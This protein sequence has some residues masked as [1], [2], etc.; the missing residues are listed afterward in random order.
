M[1]CIQW[2]SLVTQRKAPISILKWTK[3]VFNNSLESAWKFSP[4]VKPACNENIKNKLESSCF[5]NRNGM[6]PMQCNCLEYERIIFINWNTGG[7][8]IV[9]GWKRWAPPVLN[10][11][12]NQIISSPPWWETVIPITM[13]YMSRKTCISS[14]QIEP[15][16]SVQQIWLPICIFPYTGRWPHSFIKPHHKGPRTSSHQARIA[17]GFRLLINH[18][19]CPRHHC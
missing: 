16:R 3:P 14:G 4:Y 19:M 1:T 13:K 17:R 2:Y 11:T 7:V 9:K 5:V 12:H 18:R 8:I 10:L 15:N 6:S